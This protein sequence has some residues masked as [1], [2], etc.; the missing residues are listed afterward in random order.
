VAVLE[1]VEEVQRLVV[2][3][4]WVEPLKQH[5][6]TFGRKPLQERLVTPEGAMVGVCDVAQAMDA[7]L[8]PAEPV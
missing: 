2:P 3:D 7:V 4:T 6:T 1:R 5:I 8:L